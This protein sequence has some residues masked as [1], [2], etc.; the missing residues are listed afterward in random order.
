MWTPV[1]DREERRPDILRAV[2]Q[3][4]SASGS[5]DTPA[6]VRIGTPAWN[7]WRRRQDLLR[8]SSQESS[9]SGADTP[10]GP[11]AG[12]PAW[13]AHRDIDRAASQEG[14]AARDQNPA[15]FGTGAWR[16][17]LYAAQR[18]GAARCGSG[19]L[20]PARSVDSPRP[21]PDAM[22][23]NLCGAARPA[24]V[25]TLGRARSEADITP[26]TATQAAGMA[27]SHADSLGDSGAPV[28]SACRRYPWQPCCMQFAHRRPSL[29]WWRA[30]FAAIGPGVV[31]ISG[32]GQQTRTLKPLSG[33]HGHLPLLRG[34]LRR[35]CSMAHGCHCAAPVIDSKLDAWAA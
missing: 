32:R 1:P 20:W 30:E 9:T 25:G 34:L 26:A 12:V 19:R 18:V 6:G 4:S 28:S 21:P 14:R 31:G 10:A 11:R 27:Q 3:G 5:E 35:L 17:D 13:H 29:R 24:K 2:S 33:L 7:A 16:Y 23:H 8:A 22:Q 15:G